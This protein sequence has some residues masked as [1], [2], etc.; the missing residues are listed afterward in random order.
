MSLL[1]DLYIPH[2]EDRNFC[3]T[4]LD[5]SFPRISARLNQVADLNI[6]FLRNGIPAD[7]YAIRYVEIY[8]IAVLP[9]NLVA[10]IPIDNCDLTSYPSPACQEGI[11]A[12]DGVCG[13]ESEEDTVAVAGKYHLPFLIPNDF[14]APAIYFDVWYYYATDPR[15]AEGTEGADCEIDDVIYEDQLLKCCHRFWV[16]P[17]GWLCDDGL[18]TARFSFE[19][20]DKKFYKPEVRNLEVGL[21]PLP[22]YD[23]NFNLV[24]PMIPFLQPE[25]MFETMNCELLVDWTPARIGVRQGSYRSNPLVVQYQVDTSDFIKGTYYYRIRLTLPTGTT[26]MSDKFVLAIG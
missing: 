9:Q 10:T 5:D 13:T 11:A 1:L 8:K 14:V 20:L 21:M 4:E 25:I 2:E 7:P 26:I 6:T 24:N 3:T 17:D 22:L 16:Y 18:Q 15:F 12:E 19:P 23:Y